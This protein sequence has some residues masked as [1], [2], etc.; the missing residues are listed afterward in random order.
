MRR[1]VKIKTARVL[2]RKAALT[3]SPA[4][5]RPFPAWITADDSGIAFPAKAAAIP[6]V[7]DGLVLRRV[8]KQKNKGGKGAANESGAR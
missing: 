8:A 2:V 4:S 5:R 6:R 3:A 1:L 7:R